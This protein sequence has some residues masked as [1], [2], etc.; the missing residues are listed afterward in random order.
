MGTVGLCLG[1]KHMISVVATTK[2]HLVT[3]LKEDILQA[4]VQFPSIIFKMA[5]HA[6]ATLQAIQGLG[7][8]VDTAGKGKHCIVADDRPQSRLPFD[9]ALDTATGSSTG[10]APLSHPPPPTQPKSPPVE[11]TPRSLSGIGPVRQCSVLS[12]ALAND[13]GG[14]SIK[15]LSDEDFGC[16]QPALSGNSSPGVTSKLSMG[17]RTRSP[18]VEPASDQDQEESATGSPSSTRFLRKTFELKSGSSSPFAKKRNPTSDQDQEE[19]PSGSPLSMRVS[20]KSF[21]LKSGSSSITQKRS[22]TSDQDQEESPTGPPTGSPLAGSPLSTRFS[23]KSFE[24]SSS[25]TKKRNPTSDQDQEESPS[26]SPLSTRFSRKSFELSS[27]FTKK[28]NPTSDQDQEESPN[29][30]PT[31]SPT[32]TRV[33]RKSL[34]RSSSFTKNSDPTNDQNKVG[35]RKKRASFTHFFEKQSTVEPQ[36]V[37]VCH[38][39]TPSE[40]QLS[41]NL[42]QQLSRCQSILSNGDV[43]AHRGLLHSCCAAVQHAPG[44]EGSGGNTSSK[45]ADSELAECVAPIEEGWRGE[46]AG[47]ES[48]DYDSLAMRVL[49]PRSAGVYDVATLPVNDAV[50]NAGT[51][52]LSRRG[53]SLL[54]PGSEDT[55]PQPQASQAVTGQVASNARVKF[56]SCAL[57]GGPATRNRRGSRRA[58]WMLAR[59]GEDP[60]AA[61]AVAVQIDY[62]ACDR[63]KSCAPGG[64]SAERRGSWML[65]RGGADSQAASGQVS[66]KKLTFKPMVQQASPEDELILKLL[67]DWKQSSLEVLRALVVAFELLWLPLFTSGLST[68]LNAPLLVLYRY[69]HL[70]INPSPNGNVLPFDLHPNSKAKLLLKSA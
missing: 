7:E 24:L 49:I 37:G 11:T 15:T 22:P 59:G 42:E 33:S 58:S 45:P 5:K 46:A 61:P 44:M 48:T 10:K 57:G 69:S 55:M 18:K 43:Q 35:G 66:S 12:T 39:M 40:K 56:R 21:E 64:G 60:Q 68:E 38:C 19:S 47:G 25:F 32:P 20:R 62:N 23:R 34:H 67:T 54:A 26:G 63:S 30:S 31:G 29:G 28:R 51:P 13:K 27:S 1:V 65:V 16:T 4:A 52:E 36:A 50:K 8:A 2:C 6:E 53:S 9:H 70:E 3:V 17:V 14:F 41:N